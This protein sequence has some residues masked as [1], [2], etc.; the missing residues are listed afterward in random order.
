MKQFLDNLNLSTR[1]CAL[2]L[3]LGKDQNKIVHRV[4]RA[5][6][7]HPYKYGKV[8]ALLHQD[9]ANRVNFFQGMIHRFQVE[10]MILD[11]IIWSDECT[12]KVNVIFNN[13]NFVHWNDENPFNV[14]ATKHQ[15]RWMINICCGI[16]GDHLVNKLI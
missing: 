2:R 12:F 9:P 7:F 1:V 10:P 11:R 5:Q 3:M 13:K 14:R 6:G 8:K 15:Y 4:L 16:F